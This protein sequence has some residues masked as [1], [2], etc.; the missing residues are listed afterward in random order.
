[1]GQ[2][3][4]FASPEQVRALSQPVDKRP[5]DV[6]DVAEKKEYPEQQQIRQWFVMKKGIPKQNGRH[7][8][9]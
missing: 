3:N 5:N 1:M 2:R 9:A 4:G 7:E 6:V 8:Q